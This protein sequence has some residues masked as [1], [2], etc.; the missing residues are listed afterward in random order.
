[1]AMKGCAPRLSKADGFATPAKKNHCSVIES[2]LSREAIFQSPKSA[3]N[4]HAALLQRTTT[5]LWLG[6]SAHK[7]PARENSRAHLD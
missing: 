3:A 2:K 6:E 1:M 5:W 4:G 7:H